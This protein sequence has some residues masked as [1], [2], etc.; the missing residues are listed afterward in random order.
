MH[1]KLLKLLSLGLLAS[2]LAVTGYS[3]VAIANSYT[4]NFNSIGSGLSAGWGVWNSATTTANG[5]AAT[6]ATA[7]TANDAA[8]SATT[9]FRNLPG[10]SQ[11]WATSLS[12]G[13]DRALG[14]RA[15][16]ASNRDGAITFSL[17]STAG[18]EFSS[19]SFD[20]FTPNSSGTAGTF[21]L[22]Y[23]L[24]TS[25]TFITLPGTSYSNNTAGN[26][27]IVTH[28]SLS[29]LELTALNNYAGQ[30][31][32]RFNNTATTNTTFNTLALDN[33]SYTAT[34]TAVPEPSTYALLGG[35]SVLVLAGVARSSRQRS[36]AQLSK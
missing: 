33:F 6:F 3:Q 15:G 34:A 32:L 2:T 19:L 23:Q 22:E 30:V 36:S 35:V 13:A 10:A 18:W 4:E 21:V 14:W 27:L 7:L 11:T 1:H 20:L 26:P 12:A 5:T 9:A 17:T 16:L 28:V 24:G 25:G 8:T 29:A 31:T